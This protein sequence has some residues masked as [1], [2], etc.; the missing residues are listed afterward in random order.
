MVI[1]LLFYCGYRFMRDYL[2]LHWRSEYLMAINS[3][4]DPYF[5]SDFDT[6]QVDSGLES[7]QRDGNSTHAT[8]TTPSPSVLYRIELD[9]DS[10]GSAGGYGAAR[11]YHSSGGE[12]T[13]I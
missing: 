11:S 8:L 10:S 13:D 5:S 1:L 3:N 2:K 7:A 9:G 4:R 12:Y 6:A